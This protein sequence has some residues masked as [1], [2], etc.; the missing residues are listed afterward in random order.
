MDDH[1]DARLFRWPM[2]AAMRMPRAPVLLLIAS[3]STP[4]SSLDGGDL[5]GVFDRDASADAP[6]DARASR[7]KD[8]AVLDGSDVRDARAE[9]SA[10]PSDGGARRARGALG[11]RCITPEG[12]PNRD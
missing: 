9:D 2:R 11:E 10:A 12:V 4:S 1:C 5:M 3:C 6:T 8:A 7:P